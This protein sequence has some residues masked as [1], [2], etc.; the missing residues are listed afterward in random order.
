MGDL[1]ASRKVVGTNLGWVVMRVREKERG[2][3]VRVDLNRDLTQNLERIIVEN[4]SQKYIY[5]YIYY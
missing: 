2:I 5:I 4:D 3:R 1:K